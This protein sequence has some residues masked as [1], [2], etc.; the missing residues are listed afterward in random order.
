MAEKAKSTVFEDN[1]RV[2][3]TE[4][5][6]APGTETGNHVHELDYTVVPLSTGTL[7]IMDSDGESENNIV[8]GRPYFRRSGAEH[9]VVNRS[10]QEIAFVEIEV[11]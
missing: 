10:D 5:R 2:R 11:K 8:H 1:D 7:I 4:W 6:F 9:N 3:V